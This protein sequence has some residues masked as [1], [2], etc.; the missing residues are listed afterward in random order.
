MDV[1]EY[2]LH[3]DEYLQTEYRNTHHIDNES[4]ERLVIQQERSKTTTKQTK[5]KVDFTDKDS[6]DNQLGHEE[7][8]VD[9][10]RRE[11]YPDHCVEKATGSVGNDHKSTNAT[12]LSI[13]EKQQHQVYSEEQTQKSKLVYTGNEL[14]EL[15]LNPERSF[16]DVNQY[17]LHPERYTEGSRDLSSSNDSS[18]TVSNQPAAKDYA[19][20]AT[21]ANQPN[22]GSKAKKVIGIPAHQ[23]TLGQAEGPKYNNR[24]WEKSV[25]DLDVESSSPGT[26]MDK[27]NKN[28]SAPPSPPGQQSFEKHWENAWNIVKPAQLIQNEVEGIATSSEGVQV[29]EDVG[30]TKAPTDENV[31]DAQMSQQALQSRNHLTK[32]AERLID[33]II[34]KSKE[35]MLEM[36]INDLMATQKQDFET[37]VVTN[38][39]MEEEMRSTVTEVASVHAKSSS[40]VTV[41]MS[42]DSS[43]LL[44]THPG[45]SYSSGD[46]SATDD[47]CSGAGWTQS[48]DSLNSLLLHKRCTQSKASM[49]NLVLHKGS[50]T[51]T[52]NVAEIQKKHMLNHVAK[53]LSN[54]I[55]RSAL[56]STVSLIE[57]RAKAHAVRHRSW[58]SFHPNANRQPES[59]DV[60]DISLKRKASSRI[61]RTVSA[62]VA[63][64][65]DASSLGKIAACTMDSILSDEVIGKVEQTVSDHSARSVKQ[66]ATDL[67]TKLCA[68]VQGDFRR[69]VRERL[70]TG[71]PELLCSTQDQAVEQIQAI[72]AM[73]DKAEHHLRENMMPAM[74]ENVVHL[75]QTKAE[76][77]SEFDLHLS[78]NAY[79]DQ[80][81]ETVIANTILRL[82]VDI[83][84]QKESLRE[85][86]APK[87]FSMGHSVFS[88]PQNYARCRKVGDRVSFASQGTP[89]S[90]N[91]S[92]LISINNNHI[93]SNNNNSCPPA[94]TPVSANRD[95]NICEENILC[96]VFTKM[97]SI[98][99]AEEAEV[100]GSSQSMRSSDIT[101]STDSAQ[102]QR[103]AEVT[104][105]ML[106]QAAGVYLVDRVLCTA[107]QKLQQCC[108]IM[109]RNRSQ[110]YHYDYMASVGRGVMNGTCHRHTLSILAETVAELRNL[111][112]NL[113]IDDVAKEA[114]Y[115]FVQI[116]SNFQ[117]TMANLCNPVHGTTPHDDVLNSALPDDDTGSKVTTSP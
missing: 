57:V 84:Q 103:I 55:T 10:N 92:P 45:R 78:M 14:P 104:Q 38:K 87:P 73:L 116:D 82:H 88:K 1:H 90:S 93:S 113:A 8:F 70:S 52:P 30:K 58:S 114:L 95:V 43:F 21:G 61:L 39:D 17:A 40:D 66:Y 107:A 102:A 83:S 16:M 50:V 24:K 33:Q 9:I 81:M 97:Y 117:Q 29:H 98:L 112:L 28:N 76:S 48:E 5:R 36:P 56:E 110:L 18:L 75:L 106:G 46:Q 105:K 49:N 79:A 67:V 53:T 7:S 6:P 115:G 12:I 64:S 89:D 68:D 65:L 101:P 72:R 4:S 74:V 35:R 51:S 2:A 91:R 109:D 77:V 69:E 100:P 27:A 96:S 26:D 23:N 54:S 47:S 71:Y 34:T 59:L 11:D 85:L 44:L 19:E 111:T 37:S 3:Q 63:S 42:R 108:D 80:Y 25:K 13:T 94:T 86:D 62:R 31:L 41:T 20:H 32:F 15:P 60:D 22:I 99:V